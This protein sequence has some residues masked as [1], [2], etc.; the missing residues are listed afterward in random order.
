MRTVLR[1]YDSTTA[2]VDK[3]ID[4][5]RGYN[6]VALDLSLIHI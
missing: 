4:I 6:D 5:I 1:K 3:F 2:L